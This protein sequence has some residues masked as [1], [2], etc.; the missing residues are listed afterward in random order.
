MLIL[1]WYLHLYMTSQERSH[2]SVDA[3]M[4]CQVFP[5]DSDTAV[6]HAHREICK[7][8]VLHLPHTEGYGHSLGRS[9]ARLNSHFSLK[10]LKRQSEQLLRFDFCVQECLAWL[11]D[12]RTG[13]GTLELW[14][15]RRA[16]VVQEC[17]PHQATQKTHTK[18]TIIDIDVRVYLN[19]P[20]HGS[21]WVGI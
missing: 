20:V 5:T 3:A 1:D 2:R 6:W 7:D 9:V 10:A 16:P 17:W 12:C 15:A 8:V 11:S 13:V 4:T 19:R 14:L 18:N 21:F